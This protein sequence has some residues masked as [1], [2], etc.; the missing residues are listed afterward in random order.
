MRPSARITCYAYTYI[1]FC[2]SVFYRGVLLFLEEKEEK[3]IIIGMNVFEN[4]E[5][6]IF[7]LFS[8]VFFLVFSSIFFLFKGKC[9]CIFWHILKTHTRRESKYSLGLLR[10]K[11]SIYV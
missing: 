4:D 7:F 10:G 9:I 6:D 5:S 11:Y 8:R 1:L 3:S 2:S